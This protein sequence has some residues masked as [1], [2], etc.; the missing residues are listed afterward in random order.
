MPNI[1][2]M[3]GSLQWLAMLGLAAVLS[4]GAFFGVYRGQKNQNAATEE[5]LKAKIAENSELES[6]RPRLVQID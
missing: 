3:P 4:V 1:S 5:Q 2:D 6:Y